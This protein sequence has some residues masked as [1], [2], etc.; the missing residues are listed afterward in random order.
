MSIGQVYFYCPAIVSNLYGDYQ[1]NSAVHA[2]CLFCYTCHA[3][4]VYQQGTLH[5]VIA[6]REVAALTGTST[7]REAATAYR[8]A[9]FGVYH[10]VSV[11]SN[12][13]RKAMQSCGRAWQTFH[14]AWTDENHRKMIAMAEGGMIP[15]LMG[16]GRI[17]DWSKA[18]SRENR[19][20]P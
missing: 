8:R 3:Q 12:K 19:D 9:S 16:K 11:F 1:C 6:S 15:G 4:F 2:G 20:P 10:R 17:P 5:Q 7:L 18:L 14:G 13:I